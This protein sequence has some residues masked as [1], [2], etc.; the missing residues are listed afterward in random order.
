MHFN[1]VMQLIGRMIV[2]ILATSPCF[3]RNDWTLVLL[4][5][6]ITLLS[7]VFLT[8]VHTIHWYTELWK[9]SGSPGTNCH[10]K[11][12][13]SVR[14]MDT[15][16]LQQQTCSYMVPILESFTV[17]LQHWK[18]IFAISRPASSSLQPHH[19]A[20]KHSFLHPARGRLALL[21]C[22]ILKF[23]AA[24]SFFGTSLFKVFKF[25][26]YSAEIKVWARYEDLVHLYV[27]MHD[28]PNKTVQCWTLL[29]AHP[30]LL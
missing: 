16:Q 6:E 29:A 23:N 24:Q 15:S 27:N 26:S 2:Y 3:W 8:S 25:Y 30:W 28:C 11:Y 9:H 17:T 20:V 7:F 13:G 12:T 19:I 14:R 22:S 5:L 18:S 1:D 4:T 10:Q 21:I